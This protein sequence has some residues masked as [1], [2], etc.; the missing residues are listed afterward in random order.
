MSIDNDAPSTFP[1]GTERKPYAPM[2]GDV[3]DV[4]CRG[5]SPTLGAYGTRLATV[6]R[7][8]QA[9]GCDLAWVRLPGYEKPELVDADALTL[10]YRAKPERGP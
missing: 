5:L 1:S 9:H 7:P 8:T 10:V 2:P 6:E 3:V 4:D